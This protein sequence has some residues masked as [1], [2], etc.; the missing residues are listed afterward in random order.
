[1]EVSCTP[2]FVL[3]YRTIVMPTFYR[4]ELNL[5]VSL[6]SRITENTVTWPMYDMTRLV[7]C[8]ILSGLSTFTALM[9][10][11]W[12]QIYMPL[13]HLYTVLLA[14]VSLRNDAR[15]KSI[16]KKHL[17]IV[18]FVNLFVYTYRDLYPLATF[19]LT[20]HDI[21]EGSILWLKIII[22]I[23]IG[24]VIPVITPR[25]HTCID[26]QDSFVNVNP[27]QTASVWSLLTYSFMDPIIFLASKVSHLSHETLPPL[28]KYDHAEH[29]KRRYFRGEYIKMLFLLVAQAIA[30]FSS[31]LG[32][33]RLLH[34]IETGG[35]ESYFRPWFWV[36]WLFMGP[37][38][39][40]ITLQWY[41]YLASRTIAQVEA[42]VTQLVFE[43]SL[44]IRLKAET[45]NE[46][47]IKGIVPKNN[48]YA[49]PQEDDSESLTASAG[50]P[51]M[52]KCPVS[53][54]LIGKINNL[55]TTDM[56]NMR[57]A[58][59]FMSILIYIPL[60]ILFA[61]WFL[62]V[63]LGWSAFVGL[64]VIVGLFPFPGYIT[65]QIQAVEASRMKRTDARVQ[66]VTEI[67]NVI[68]MIKL[69]GWER[70]MNQKIEE[71][72]DEELI[73]MWKRQ[74]LNLTKGLLKY[75]LLTPSIQTLIMK[76]DLNASKV[77]SSMAVFD[78]LR[79]QLHLV[80]HTVA[81]IVTGKV[82]IDRIDD[83]LQNTELLD[84]YL[85]RASTIAQVPSDDTI[86]FRSAA[87]T[88]SADNGKQVG[89]PQRPF[90]LQIPG[91]LRFE[92]GCI[93]LITGPTGSGKTS[94]LMALL[95]EMYYLPSGADS[96][97]N[98]PRHNGVAYAAQESWVLN[99][100]I[101]ENIIFGAPLDENRY[102]KVIYQCCL[103]RDLTLLGAGDQTEV[104][105]K[106]VTLSGGQK[107][108]VTL[109]RAIYS[110]AQT[111][112]LDD[113]FAA[114]D[115][116]TTKWIIEKCIA[117]DLV[118]GRTILLVTHNF[119][120]MAPIAD[121]VVTIGLDGGISSRHA[122][123]GKSNIAQS[124][125][126]QEA[127]SNSRVMDALSFDKEEKPDGK[128]VSAEEI[129]VGNIS[130]EALKLYFSGLGGNHPFL[131]F[132]TFTGGIILSEFLFTGQTWYLG[133][134]ASQY[135][136]GNHDVAVFQSVVFSPPFFM[137]TDL[138]S[139]LKIYGVLLFLALAVFF[140]ACVV[141]TFGTLRASRAIHKQLVTSVLGTT[142]RWL[143]TTPTSRV[144]TRCTQDIGAV[145]GPI[146]GMIQWLSELTI[147]MLVK[148]G[149]VVILTP[150]FFGPGITVALVGGWCCRIYM[151]AQLSVKREMSN[152]KTPILGQC[153]RS[154]CFCG[155][156]KASTVSIRAYGAQK[157]FIIESLRRIDRHTRA[158]RTFFN[159]NRW[160]T[161]R[162]DTIGAIFTASLAAYL[163]YFQNHTASN[164]G[165][166][167]NMAVAFSGMV[168]YWV[169][170]VNELERIQ[171]YINIEQESMPVESGIPPAYWPASGELRVEN[172]S[173][174]YSPQGEKVLDN[175]SFSVMAGERIGIVGRTGSGKSSLTL[176]LLRSIPTQ[177]LIYYDGLLINSIN[178][179]VL[180][181]SIT[182]IPQIPEMLSGTLRQN[183]DPFGQFDDETLNCALRAAGLGSLQNDADENR[184][185]LD[186]T[187]SGSG[188]NF[189]VG[190]RQILA[191]ARAI[192]R[193]SKLLILDEDH[194]TDSI[195]QSSLRHEL[196]RDVTIITVAHR[197]QTI[198]DAD[199][200]MV[201]DA[202]HIVEF[203]SPGVLLGR[204]DSM[205]RALVEESWDRDRLLALAG[206]L[207]N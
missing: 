70:N 124:L 41:T 115:V 187:I 116:H 154:F 97:Y 205:F 198:M 31:P 66:I 112:L 62:Y 166:S 105:E 122:Q 93:N 79:G 71:K 129:E 202:G 7:G 98:L 64:A 171:G 135:D 69:F 38:V 53:S 200:I 45:P 152:A 164:T 190:Q 201:L 145:D 140:T 61:T 55:V 80:F 150:I 11:D 141:Y 132:F 3:R 57:E 110:Q 127:P 136:N 144:I 179:D 2:I 89:S 183:L 109:A 17:N 99:A 131:F 157:S 83:F 184:I 85:L 37:F 175:I 151:A 40:S 182:I 75:V 161:I 74:V 185:T 67:M 156:A 158:T 26:Y 35:R 44:C 29:L 103:E 197:L 195:I 72:R 33:N 148:L 88:W 32:I 104:G 28:A 134:W 191:L 137:L 81:H 4:T 180:R 73:W 170:F 90:N 168:L 204:R 6:Y 159:L 77:F 101:K 193:G 133:H 59:D 12:S 120:L 206:D 108:R 117:G 8:L 119:T 192:V 58:R 91:E 43:H 149:A 146:A 82:S 49:V 118:K 76:Q 52:V 125:E 167:L 153:V 113:V 128:L 165:F 207:R 189:S 24:L 9:Q 78:I 194:Q 15:R 50:Q 107:A 39:S 27:E 22:L 130:W 18:L 1:M 94:L 196:G 100:T 176:S 114:L 47:S 188:G 92:H 178:L 34:Y 20:P 84:Q 48:L 126:G 160:V 147:A 177:G 121:F 86:G 21:A 10:Q 95:G 36:L 163:V 174:S 199:R 16:V 65:S 46:D 186:T 63:I 138:H 143:D 14:L 5:H 60:H 203:D 30:S 96:W 51:S 181:S 13:I 54:N 173:A 123:S 68:R 106:G 19:T 139:Y 169:Q 23:G 102:Q 42:I 142:L 155:Y 87:F 162:V 172:L 25:G 56:A 111:L